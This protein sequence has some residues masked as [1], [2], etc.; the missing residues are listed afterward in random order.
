MISNLVIHFR[1]IYERRSNSMEVSTG[2]LKFVVY[3]LIALLLGV[4]GYSA[5]SEY[6][7]RSIVTRLQNDLA[8]RDKTIEVKE[9]LFSRLSVT[10]SELKS[11]LDTKDKQLDS[12]NKEIVDKHEELLT[13]N[14][15]VLK[16]KK[17]YEG[18]AAAIQTEVIE[19]EVTREIRVPVEVV[20][21]VKIPA[22]GSRSVSSR[23]RVDFKKD[24]G[25]IGVLGYTLTNPAEAW[26]Q[27]NQN[28][29]L[30]LSLSISED[31]AHRWKAY[32]TSSED[33]IPVDISLSA[34]NPFLFDKKWYERIE[35]SANLGV[36]PSALVGVGAGL[37]I[38]K[39]SVGPMFWATL[40]DKVEKFYGLSVTWRPFQRD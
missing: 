12:L 39:F 14:S 2:N 4:A 32:A 10:T 25:H 1:N 33:N 38:G 21:E 40:S 11:L 22:D 30:K 31:S 9:G 6:K 28:R 20:K 13:T 16:W 15:L 27:V 8:T 24:F 17:A 5:Y 23:T 7:H 35:V 26:V 19:K 34:V 36:G 18:A 29:P 37:Q 3:L